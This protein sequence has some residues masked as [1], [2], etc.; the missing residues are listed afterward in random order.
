MRPYT[1]SPSQTLGPSFIL[2][3]SIFLPVP[4]FPLHSSLNLPALSL[5]LSHSSSPSFFTACSLLGVFSAPQRN[6]CVHGSIVISLEPAPA[7]APLFILVGRALE[8]GGVEAAALG[9]RAR[10][11]HGLRAHRTEHRGRAANP[12]IPDRPNWFFA[13]VSDSPCTTI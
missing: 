6:I 12:V 8:R 5:F 11:R 13:V 9:G 4:S 1:Q 2:T 7:F 10:G 3:S